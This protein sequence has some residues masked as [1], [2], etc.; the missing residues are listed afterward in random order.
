MKHILLSLCGRT[1]QILTETLYC[2]MVNDHPVSIDEIW[3]VT[4]KSGK[5]EACK[6]LLDEKNGKFY[7][8]CHEYEIDPKRIIFSKANIIAPDDASDIQNVHDNES[9][10]NV[11]TQKVWQLTKE[12]DTTLHCSIAGGRKTMSAYMAMI[13]QFFA[14]SQDRMFHILTGSPD[15][16]NNREFYFPPKTPVFISTQDG[17]Q[18]STT[19]SGLVLVDI[20][21]IRLREKIKEFT[22]H[23]YLFSEMVQ[24]AQ[25][26]ISSS[27]EFPQ[28][29]IDRRSGDIHIGNK[30]S[31]KLPKFQRCIYSFIAEF[32]AFRDESIP[33]WDYEKYFLLGGFSMRREDELAFAKLYDSQTFKFQWEKL[34]QGISRVNKVLKDELSDFPL[35]DYYL[36]SIVGEYGK[37][38]YGLK[39]DKK[40]ITLL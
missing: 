7:Q 22:S 5:E 4:T 36:I 3:I 10:A 39:L 31:C 18:V 1:P 40:Y 34:Q 33:A 23:P 12:P 27:Q 13:M 35:L 25:Q 6:H 24:L 17:R 20:P 14:R 8:F 32:S 38:Y 16:E 2:L 29:L 19:D 9:F 37:K 28:L 11:L 30:Y 26:W 15:F 21:F